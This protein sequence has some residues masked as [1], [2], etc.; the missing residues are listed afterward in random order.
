MSGFYC[1]VRPDGS[2]GVHMT[3]NGIDRIPVP[4]AIFG[5]PRDAIRYAEMRD[6]HVSPMREPVETSAVLPLVTDVSASPLTGTHRPRS[7]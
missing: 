3:T 4:T 1:H 6:Q 2:Y 5:K 7:R